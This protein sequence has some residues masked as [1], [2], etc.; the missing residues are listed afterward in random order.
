MLYNVGAWFITYAL[1]ALKLIIVFHRQRNKQPDVTDM[2]EI[3]IVT[4]DEQ[5]ET[6]IPASDLISDIPAGQK[7]PYLAVAQ[8]CLVKAHIRS[9]IV[10]IE[11]EAT[12]EFRFA[13]LSIAAGFIA[14]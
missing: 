6:D 7:C 12:T 2:T 11:V 8:T 9:D 5:T 1:P 13:P 4:V 3:P 10:S 14:I